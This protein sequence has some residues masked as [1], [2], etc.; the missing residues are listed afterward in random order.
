MKE[1]WMNILRDSVLRDF[2]SAGAIYN[3]GFKW[4]LAHFA[5]DLVW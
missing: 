1:K 5:D 2:P 3:G 4:S